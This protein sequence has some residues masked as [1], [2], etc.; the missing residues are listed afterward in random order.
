MAEACGW[1]FIHHFPQNKSFKHVN[2]WV[3]WS[4]TE[5]DM[6]RFSLEARPWI[7]RAAE[8]LICLYA[9]L[10]THGRMAFNPQRAEVKLTSR[11]ER[12]GERGRITCTSE[13]SARLIQQT[14]Y[15]SHRR[16]SII[17]QYFDWHVVEKK[18]SVSSRLTT[19][20][21]HGFTARVLEHVCIF[22][23]EG[24]PSLCFQFV[25]KPQLS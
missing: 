23:Q 11:P 9:L 25:E 3:P 10:I 21:L 16:L 24:K 12:D 15:K 20:T 19:L 14:H 4:L 5:Q 6:S 8:S 17:P 18:L 7:E 2:K 22:P 1:D 13:G